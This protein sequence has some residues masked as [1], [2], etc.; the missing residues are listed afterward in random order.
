[1]KDSFDSIL[2]F[3]RSP[4]HGGSS[5]LIE[6]KI[7]VFR[8]KGEFALATISGGFVTHFSTAESARAWATK[9]A[10]IFNLKGKWVKKK[11]SST[12]K[13]V[14]QKET[15]SAALADYL[16]DLH[17]AHD[18]TEEKLLFDNFFNKVKKIFK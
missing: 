9:A 2:W 1:M 6:P 11:I 5:E 13:S 7:H 8:K 16:K 17:V 3:H 15:L 18:D 12:K 14:T 4:V 10:E